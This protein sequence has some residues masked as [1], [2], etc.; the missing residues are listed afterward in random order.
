VDLGGGL[1]E[2]VFVEPGAVI[3]KNREDFQ[4]LKGFGDLRVNDYIAY[5]GLSGCGSEQPFHAFVIVIGD[6]QP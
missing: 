5:F 6:P 2:K 1:T 4:E 3:L